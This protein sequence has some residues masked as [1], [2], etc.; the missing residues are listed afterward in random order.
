M[1]APTYT[2]V[3][4]RTWRSGPGHRSHLSPDG[5]RTTLCK[6]EN[7]IHQRPPLEKLFPHLI[8][9][10]ADADALAKKAAHH[11]CRRLCANCQRRAEQ[12]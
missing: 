11:S 3:V 5:G 2:L 8:A 9:P 4:P 1:K 7:N 12:P 6:V 10:S